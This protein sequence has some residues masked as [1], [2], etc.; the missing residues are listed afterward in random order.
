MQEVDG[1]S[2]Q[3]LLRVCLFTA[4]LRSSLHH[5]CSL[6]FSYMCVL[7]CR[8]KMWGLGISFPQRL[9]CRSSR[10]VAFVLSLITLSWK[11]HI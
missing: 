1:G 5:W 9:A 10:S 11:T 2:F 3:H 7:R 6:F 4:G 8:H